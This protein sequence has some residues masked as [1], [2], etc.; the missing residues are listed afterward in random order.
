MWLGLFCICK[1]GSHGNG[2]LVRVA[3][4]LIKALPSTCHMGGVFKA[5]DRLDELRTCENFPYN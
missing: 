3:C 5:R 1:I 4:D 2:W